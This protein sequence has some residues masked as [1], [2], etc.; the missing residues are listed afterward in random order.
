MEHYVGLDLHSNNTLVAISDAKD[1]RIFKKRCPNDLMLILSVLAPYKDTIKEIA[2]ESTFNWYWLVDG[3]MEAGYPVVL[4]HPAGMQKYSGLKHS[5]DT[6]DAF[7]LAHL[8]RLGILPQGHIYPKEDRQLRDLLRKRL[9]LVHQST[10]HILSFQSLM[11]RNVCQS[12]SSNTIKKLKEEDIEGMLDDEYLTLSAQSNIYM[13]DC[14][15]KRIK[16]IEKKLLKVTRQRPQFQKLYD[17]PG[18]GEI[19]GLTIYLETGNINRF[20]NDGKYAS[21]CRCVDSKCTSNKKKKGENNRKNG[22]KYLAWA[23]VEA[24]N[25]MRR[26][27]GKALAFYNRKLAKTNKNIATKSLACKICKA[28]YHVMKKNEDYDPDRLFA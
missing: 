2:V 20:K 14:A 18:I 22:N 3:L 25:F 7:W 10:T 24:A 21:Y 26:Y 28:C 5:D 13:R 6:D 27:C 16:L 17:I 8:L 23:Y 1:N 12:V 4:A 9:I 15:A 19:L 11:N